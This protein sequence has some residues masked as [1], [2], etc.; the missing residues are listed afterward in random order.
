MSADHQSESVTDQTQLKSKME[1]NETP[2]ETKVGAEDQ[3]KTSDESHTKNTLFVST[4]PFDATSEDLAAFFGTIG[5]IRSCFVV[6]KKAGE[7]VTGN[8]AGEA[9]GSS[10]KNANTG[11]GYVQFAM[12][13]DAQRALTELKKVKFQGKRTLRMAL[14]LKKRVAL[15][16]KGKGNFE[17]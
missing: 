14:A 1:S 16:R 4:I 10:E 12:A 7:A 13:E 3:K 15:E 11:I 17:N 6:K 8:D 9:E 5:P 2:A